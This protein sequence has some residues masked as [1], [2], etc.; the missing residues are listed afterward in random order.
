MQMVPPRRWRVGVPIHCRR[1]TYSSSYNCRVPTHQGLPLNVATIREKICVT[2]PQTQHECARR[3][4]AVAS[5]SAPYSRLWSFL[6]HIPTVYHIL[7][8]LRFRSLSM[9]EQSS[10]HRSVI[11]V[12]QSLVTGQA[13]VAIK[14]SMAWYAH[15]CHVPQ[16]KPRARWTHCFFLLWL[17]AVNSVVE[18]V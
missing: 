2:A 1:S 7:T 10:V 3:C 11:L 14:V 15:I 12:H 6:P 13:P 9:H 16:D 4:S 17:W 18:T 8:A 5:R